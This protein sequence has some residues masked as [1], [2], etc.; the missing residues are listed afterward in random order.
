MRLNPATHIIIA[1]EITFF[2]ISLPAVT[3]TEVLFFFFIISL[4]IP[5]RTDFRLTGE[6]LKI[7]GVGAVFLFLIHG[8]HW[9]PLGIAHDGLLTGLESL[10]RIATPVICVIYLSRRIR[11]EELFAMLIDYRVPPLI[12]LILFRTLW[13]VPR[14]TERMDEVLTAQK[15]RGMRIETTMQRIRALI[16]TLNPIFSSMLNEISVNAL[17]MTTRGFLLPG[18]KTHFTPL[19]YRW[20]DKAVIAGLTFFLGVLWF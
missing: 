10:T 12:I 13:L 11:S 5:A 7:L 4:S 19:S 9:H 18:R 2:A 16:P 15:L 14:L 8:V 20:T 1:L 17:T 6:F 3:G